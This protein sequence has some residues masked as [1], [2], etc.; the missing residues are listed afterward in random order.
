M[1]VSVQAIHHAA[2]SLVWSWITLI[3]CASGYLVHWLFSYNKAVQ[4]SKALGTAIPGPFD[5]WRASWAV[6]W[7]SFIAV[8]AGYVLIPELG[9]TWPSVGK[10][11]GVVAEDG[12]LVGLTNLSAFLWGIGG[13][14]FADYAGKRMSTMLQ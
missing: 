5:Y 9:A 13:P 6:S 7:A 4:G 3:M 8:F 14:F 11:F 10:F 12:T 2:E 1:N